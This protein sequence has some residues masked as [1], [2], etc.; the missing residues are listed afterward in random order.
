VHP[1]GRWLFAAMNRAGLV[2]VFPLGADGE[3]GS[4][5]CSV[6]HEGRG[7]KSPNQDRAFPHSTWLD[8]DRKRLFVC[9]LALD[10][11]MVYDFDDSSGQLTPA[12]R[13]F[14]QISSGAGPRH[15]AF[16]PAGHFVYVLNE[17]DSTISAF[18]Y[19]AASARL[20][21]VQTVSALP[22]DFAGQSAAAQIQVHPSG[23]WLYASNRGHDSIAMFAI[24]QATGR[25]RLVGHEPSL[26]ERPHN[27]TLD[28]DGQ[29]MVVANQR[30]GQ[31]ASFHV[32]EETGALRPA[33]AF[34]VTAPVCVVLR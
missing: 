32:D 14:A 24:D 19:D 13:P 26:G 5:V 17:L 9:D 16:H 15:L 29:L 23:R 27:F 18:A 12:E 21:I 6:Q 28:P 7:P 20:T 4:P 34:A 31:V 30:S 1:D 8:H 33:H 22:D 10:R 2:G 3:V 25:L 11:V